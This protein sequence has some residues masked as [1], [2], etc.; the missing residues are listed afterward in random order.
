[1]LLIIEALLLISSALGR[2]HRDAV[3]EHKLDMALNS[4]DDYY[5]GCRQNMAK[6]VKEKYLNEKCDNSEFERNGFKNAWQKG[7]SYVSN[8]KKMKHDTLKCNFIAIYVYTDIDFKIYQIFNNDA[9]NGKQNYKD[10][11]Y[12]WYSLQFLLT[13]AIEILRKKQNRC[14]KTFRGTNLTFNEITFP[15][16]RF[17]SFTSSSLDRYIAKRFGNKS[18]FEIYTCLGADV[19]EYSRLPYEKEVLIPPYE[20]FKVTAVRT[21]K[22]QKD[23]WC[24]T[25]YTLKNSG[26]RSELNCALF[27]PPK[28]ITKHY[29]VFNFWCDTVLL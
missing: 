20:K 18:C 21:K 3:E 4:V 26:T 7:E 22:Y 5:Y 10:G 19:S 23:L 9:R 28:N 12:K 27:K 16:I 14:F 15:E 6:K 11:T 25:V 8:Q 24:E 13:E 17:G 29:G 1:M 2:D